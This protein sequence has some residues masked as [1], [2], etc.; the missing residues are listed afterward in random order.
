M[1]ER[2]YESM[3]TTSEMAR[4]ASS[5]TGTGRANPRETFCRQAPPPS[6]G[7]NEDPS[8]RAERLF[9]DVWP[10]MDDDHRTP[11]TETDRTGTASFRASRLP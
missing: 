4:A 6:A 3:R 2:V 9:D 5:S 7:D 8:G 11:V 10:E 1:T